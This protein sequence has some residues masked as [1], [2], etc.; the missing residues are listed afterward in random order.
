VI[1]RRGDVQNDQFI[2][3]LDVV[4]RRK[5]G[6]IAGIAQVDEV[7]AFDN[8]FAVSIEARDN[9]VRQ[10]HGLPPA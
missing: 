3:A 9:A 5:R 6:R 1:A 2:S 4:P 8:A 10:A 7:H